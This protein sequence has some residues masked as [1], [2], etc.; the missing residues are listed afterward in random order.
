MEHM[1]TV[2][3]EMILS[4][5]EETKLLQPIDSYV[6]EIRRRSTPWRRRYHGVVDLQSSIYAAKEPIACLPKQSEMRPSMALRLRWSRPRRSR[7]R[8]RVQI[9]KL[10][11]DAENYLKAHYET[12]YLA[13]VKA[14]RR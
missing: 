7:L 10:I 13:P 4:V 14:S 1:P 12:E 5:D 8:T 3:G 11:A 6:N 9:D 2:S